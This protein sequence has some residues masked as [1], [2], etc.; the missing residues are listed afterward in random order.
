MLNE[1]IV[2]NHFESVPVAI[3]AGSLLIRD[4][5]PSTSLIRLQY[6]CFNILIYPSPTINETIPLSRCEL[7][8]INC[9]IIIKLRDTMFQVPILIS[10]VIISW[11]QVN[12]LI[13]PLPARFF[14]TIRSLIRMCGGKSLI[15]VIVTSLFWNMII[16]IH[17]SSPGV[18]RR[19]IIM[20]KSI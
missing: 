3:V 8:E 18:R 9:R 1:K 20:S 13:K 16:R 10:I 12:I 6:E 19:L 7:F 2:H 4:V 17:F 5:I 11:S 14:W 15:T